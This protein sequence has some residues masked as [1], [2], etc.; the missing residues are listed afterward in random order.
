MQECAVKEIKTLTWTEPAYCDV[1]LGFE[2]TAYI[3]VR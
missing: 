2:V 3:Y 1:R